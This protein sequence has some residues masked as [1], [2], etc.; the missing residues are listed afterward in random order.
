MIIMGDTPFTQQLMPKK[1]IKRGK[2]SI[3][4]YDVDIEIYIVQTSKDVSDKVRQLCRKYKVGV[5]GVKD[6]AC[7]YTATF[8]NGIFYLILCIECMDINTITHETEHLRAFIMEHRAMVDDEASAN[9]NG[10][11]N[12]RVFKFLKK[13]N[14]EIK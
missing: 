1:V 6:E 5:D 14:I 7:G 4:L 12:E 13:N 3:D 2:I 10:Y 8:L 9:L 11:I